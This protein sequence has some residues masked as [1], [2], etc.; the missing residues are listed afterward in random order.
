LADRAEALEKDVTVLVWKIEFPR[1]LW[2][3]RAEVHMAP[4]VKV[5]KLERID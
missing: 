2:R 4:V 5:E 3:V 1:L